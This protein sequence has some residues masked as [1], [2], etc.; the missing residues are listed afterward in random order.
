LEGDGNH[1]FAVVS[2]G[3]IYDLSS[4]ETPLYSHER[5]PY[6]LAISPNAMQIASSDWGGTVKVWSTREHRLEAVLSNL[7]DG[8]ISALAWTNDGRLITAGADGVVTI[9]GPQLRLIKNWHIGS[10]IRY[11][12]ITNDSVVAALANGDLWRGSLATDTEQRVALGTAITAFAVSPDSSL[13]AAGTENGELFILDRDF[14]VKAMQFEH[15]PIKCMTFQTGSSMLLCATGSRVM[16]L[17]L[18]TPSPP[19]VDG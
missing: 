8:L 2:N 13:V 19:M 17:D 11:L 18:Q 15:E 4:P 16:H 1:C 7:H 5:E 10:A 9:L 12:A 3:G 6:R 14:D